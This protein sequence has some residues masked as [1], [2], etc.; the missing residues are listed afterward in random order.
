MGFWAR[1]EGGRPSLLAIKIGRRQFRA[2]G[3]EKEGRRKFQTAE[4]E[5]S[6]G[7]R[8]SLLELEGRTEA[9]PLFLTK[10]GRKEKYILLDLDDL[11]EMYKGG[12]ASV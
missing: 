6:E 11:I 4:P 8:S 2:F 12:K 9:D 1:K 7:G 3:P 10:K 5:R